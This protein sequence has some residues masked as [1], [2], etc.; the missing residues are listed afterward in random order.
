M[1]KKCPIFQENCLEDECAAF[2]IYNVPYYY[3][4]D[5]EAYC[6]QLKKTLWIIQSSASKVKT[7]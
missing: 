3:S 6:H 2:E 5:K 7:E 4:E 1:T